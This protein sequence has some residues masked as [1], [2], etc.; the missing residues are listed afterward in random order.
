MSDEFTFIG[1]TFYEDD[2]KPD[3]IR[4]IWFRGEKGTTGTIRDKWLWCDSCSECDGMTVL[5]GVGTA[6]PTCGGRGMTINRL[7]ED[8]CDT[9]ADLVAYAPDVHDEF[10]RELLRW[11]EA[12]DEG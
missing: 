12:E 10:R 2:E 3:K 11:L 9:L 5:D 6:C 7:A 4:E 1:N 8:L